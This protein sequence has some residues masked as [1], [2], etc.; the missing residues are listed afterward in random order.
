MEE[1]EE[2]HVTSDEARGGLGAEPASKLHRTLNSGA[3]HSQLDFS[4]RLLGG[5]WE[6]FG[7]LGLQRQVKTQWRP[8]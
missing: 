5:F 7:V 8:T 1:E 6:A 4:G 2:A 3:I